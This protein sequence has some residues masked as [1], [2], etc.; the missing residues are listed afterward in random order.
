MVREAVRRLFPWEIP[1]S[2]SSPAHSELS[3]VTRDVPG[4]GVKGPSFEAGRWGR[5]GLDF[6]GATQTAFQN[7][8]KEKQGWV[9][10]DSPECRQAVLSGLGPSNLDLR[11]KMAS[12]IALHHCPFRE[13]SSKDKK[14]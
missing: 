1:G 13:S 4:T 3:Q 7:N 14:Q 2:L 9:G 11:D 8:R 10:S 6:E 5:G 12:N